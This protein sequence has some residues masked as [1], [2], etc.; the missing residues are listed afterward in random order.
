MELPPAPPHLPYAACRRPGVDREWF[1]PDRWDSPSGMRRAL[2]VC[3]GCPE[4]EPCLAYALTDRWLLG[5]WG[6]TSHLQRRHLRQSRS[7]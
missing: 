7:S 2:E 6:G 4:R 1:F 3:A 5:V